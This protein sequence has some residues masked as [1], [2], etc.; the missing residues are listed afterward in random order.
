M[1]TISVAVLA[2]LAISGTE[3][4]RLVARD[5]DLEIDGTDSFVQNEKDYS[6]YGKTFVQEGKG[7]KKINEE[8][9]DRKDMVNSGEID[10]H[11]V[12]ALTQKPKE[13]APLIQNAPPQP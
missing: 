11:P 4:A 7:I 12:P 5:D 6:T 3:A 2:L 13:K 1:K 9:Q 8:E 10:E